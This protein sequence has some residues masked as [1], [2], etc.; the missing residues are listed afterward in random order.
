MHESSGGPG[1]GGLSPPPPPPPHTHTP[2]KIS[3]RPLIPLTN[4]RKNKRRKARG[5]RR[6]WEPSNPYGSILASSLPTNLYMLIW[7]H[8]SEV[9]LDIC[10]DGSVDDFIASPTVCQIGSTS[11]IFGETL[12]TPLQQ[13]SKGLDNFW[14]LGKN[15]P[16]AHKNT[17]TQSA[18]HQRFSA[19]W[20]SGKRNKE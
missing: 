11:F 17:C 6:T 19:R 20:E 7:C 2:S 1:G 14:H 16:P 12:K 4:F 5:R 15:I 3:W 8:T 18:W 13:F 10:D 9:M